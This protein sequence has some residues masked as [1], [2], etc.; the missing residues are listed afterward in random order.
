MFS[1]APLTLVNAIDTL[2][3]DPLL[4]RHPHYSTKETGCR[5]YQRF[6]TRIYTKADGEST[7]TKKKELKK[8]KDKQPSNK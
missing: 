7:L 5:A 1:P 4:V 6:P 2:H 8:K 3:R